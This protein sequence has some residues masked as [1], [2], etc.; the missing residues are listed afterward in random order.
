MRSRLL[1]T[2]LACSVLV[3]AA[4]ASAA[5]FKV[6][7]R[8][9]NHS[10]KACKYFPGKN[11]SRCASKIWR[12]TVTARTSSGKALHASAYY[13]FLYNGQKVSTQYPSPR[14]PYSNT[15]HTPWPFTGQFTDRI[16]WPERSVG[17]PLTLR[18]VVSVRGMGTEHADWTVKVRR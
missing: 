3:P 15:A 8:A 11:A 14:S 13:Q 1:I 5:G 17:F 12:L 4:D 9:P 6:T 2:L 18:V 7:L 16:I 10:P